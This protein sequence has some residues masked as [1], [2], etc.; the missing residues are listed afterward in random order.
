MPTF[1]PNHPADFYAKKKELSIMKKYLAEK[2][3]AYSVLVD[4]VTEALLRQRP[5]TP[6]HPH[7]NR[8]Y[9]YEKFHPLDEVQFSIYNFFINSTTSPI[10][11]IDG[12]TPSNKLCQ[13][14]VLD[15]FKKTSRL[16]CH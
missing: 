11:V 16:K 1:R 13:S 2:S 7:N 10:N 15:I 6:K 5:S 3:I 12:K 9:D 14:Q 8:E 4:N